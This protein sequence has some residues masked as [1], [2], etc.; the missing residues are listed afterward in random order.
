[1]TN[2]NVMKSPGEGGGGVLGYLSDGDVQ[3]PFL[4]VKFSAWDFFR[5]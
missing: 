3:R 1:M 4:G 2:S 5:V